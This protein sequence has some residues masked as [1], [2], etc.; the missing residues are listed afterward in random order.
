MEL[1]KKDKA[2]R[3]Q[4]KLWNYLM[5]NNFYI[6]L[7]HQQ[8]IYISLNLINKPAV[9]PVVVVLINFIIALWGS[10]MIWFVASKIY[11][12]YIHF[13]NTSKGFSLG[14]KL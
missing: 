14:T 4:S 11:G 10:G 13:I 12:K 1:Y 5:K 7:I 9:P 6:Y 8:L 3:T 2:V